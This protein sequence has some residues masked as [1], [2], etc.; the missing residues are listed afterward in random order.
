MTPSSLRYA[1]PLLAATILSGCPPVELESH[2]TLAIAIE[3][4]A[5]AQDRWEGA[6]LSFDWQQTVLAY[7]FARLYA[8]TS[9][10]QYRDFYRDW[11][12]A[13]MQERWSDPA[14]PP[15]FISSDSLSPSILAAL[16]MAEDPSADYS[17]ILETADAYLA[18]V[19]RTS[20]GAVIHWGPEHPIFGDDPQ[21]W[22]DSLFM[23]GVYLVQRGAQTGDA[24]WRDD[25]AE[26][27]LAFSTHCRDEA[28]DLYRH[29]WDVD[30]EVNI[31]TDDTYWGR[32]NAWVLVSAAEALRLGGT[33]PDSVGGA[34]PLFEQHAAALVELQDGSGAWRTVVN[35]PRDDAYANYLETSATALIGYALLQSTE[36]P[37]ASIDAAVEAVISR[38][39][40]GDDGFVTLTGTSAPTN[41]SD[42]EHYV[43]VDQLDDQMT[44]IG[45][46]LMFL[47]EVH[48]REKAP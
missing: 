5:A 23:V 22:V 31:P 4:A 9:D 10:E 19:P 41:P 28:D 14:D 47:S 15:R 46:T 44:G 24:T 12:D 13:G 39:E 27:Y 29:A 33:A 8:A 16:A 17:P 26:Q 32:G 6:E 25:W 43:A 37:P 7:G 40:E 3:L 1:L 21:V 45:A 48:G 35:D 36:T 34:A 2:D 20:E 11:L 18:E 38:I 42:Y 30:D